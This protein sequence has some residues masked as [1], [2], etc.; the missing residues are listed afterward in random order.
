MTPLLPAFVG[1][2]QVDQV[3]QSDAIELFHRLPT[4]Y[5]D[6]VITDPPYCSGGVNESTKQQAK[7]QGLRAETIRGGGWFIN[8]NMTTAGL[9]WLIRQMAIEARRVIKLGGSMLI[10]T[11]WRMVSHLAPAIESAG[12]RYQNMIVWNKGSMGLGTGFRMQHEIILHFVKGTGKFY[13][14]SVGNVITTSRVSKLDREHQT[15]KPIE[16]LQELC[17]VVSPIGG[18]IFDPFCGSGTTLIAAQTL[19]RHFVGCDISAEYVE[20]ARKRLAMP[21][22]P[23]FMPALEAVS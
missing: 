18:I 14:M 3:Y 23:S 16:L 13:D 9:V 11:D 8:D 17:R 5:L 21:Y 2:P 7:G 12:L 22:T 20:V 19:E 4:D 6:A 1:A 15:Q 10:F